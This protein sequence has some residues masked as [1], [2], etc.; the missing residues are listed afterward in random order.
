VD[1]ND[2]HVW[3]RSNTGMRAHAFLRTNEFGQHVAACRKTIVRESSARMHPAE[4]FSLLTRCGVCEKLHNEYLDRIEASMAPATEADD[5]GYVHTEVEQVTEPVADQAPEDVAA[6]TEAECGRCGL[7]IMKLA[8]PWNSPSGFH[9]EWGNKF[10][11]PWCP[12]EEREAG[13]VAH[14]PAGPD[15]DRCFQCGVLIKKLAKPYRTADG[16]KSEW[17]ARYRGGLWCH[18]FLGGKHAHSPVLPFEA[19]AP[20]NGCGNCGVPIKKLA[21]PY[22]TWDGFVSEW[23]ALDNGIPWCQSTKGVMTAHTPA[24]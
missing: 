16:F 21:Q 3:A 14:V 5:L 24:E 9:A 20:G 2:T 22:R 8:R 6:G 7:P 18:N 13:P 19:Q 12:T 4:A 1:R 17:T 10:G 15:A 23:A 11:F